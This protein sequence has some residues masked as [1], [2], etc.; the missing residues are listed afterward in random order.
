MI[1][2]APIGHTTSLARRSP[3][4]TGKPN[5][6]VLS[7]IACALRRMCVADIRGR[8]DCRRITALWRASHWSDAGLH[9]AP[10][11]RRWP[12]K[13]PWSPGPA[14]TTPR[15]MKT[16]YR[17]AVRAVLGGAWLVGPAACGDE[18]DAPD[19]ALRHALCRPDARGLVF[20][21]WLANPHGVDAGREWIELRNLS[22]EPICLG[23]AVLRVQTPYSFQERVLQAPVCVPPDGLVLLGDGSDVFR[24][25]VG[26]VPVDVTYGAMELPNAAAYIDISCQE[27]SLA[28]VHYGATDAQAPSPLARHST[29][30]HEAV[31]VSDGCLA[32]TEAPAEYCTVTGPS[33]DG[34]DQGSPGEKNPACTQCWDGAQWRARRP[35]HIGDV[36]L[37][38]VYADPPG[39]DRDREWLQLVSMRDEPIDLQELSLRIIVPGRTPRRLSL[40][41]D[42]CGALAPRQARQIPVCAA[43]QN[44]TLRFCGPTL[45]NAA[46]RYELWH[47]DALID[48]ADV[49][50][51]VR[52]APA[53]PRRLSVP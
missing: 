14:A 37:G 9:L 41:S 39:P 12:R 38:D 8:F 52:N 47:V 43:A 20:N 26:G 13:V 11:R 30:R 7:P 40:H 18:W 45:P 42:G 10:V 17:C 25:R 53:R 34:R 19:L 27:T 49:A 35:L 2:Q 48:A 1:A 31:P 4:S 6:D 23:R 33:Y 50:A 46:G 16:F 21:E 24:A 22:A 15:N 44:G 3:F 36:Q 51:P 32:D 29:A 5:L 28:S